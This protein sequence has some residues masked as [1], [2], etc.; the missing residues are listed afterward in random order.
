MRVASRSQDNCSPRRPQQ[1]RGERRVADLLDAAASVFA[2]H[3]YEAATMSQV[4]ERA[5]AC[6]GSLYQFFPNK[7]VLARVLNDRFAKELHSLW[8]P[9][10]AEA[11]T[12]SVAELT[13]R[14]VEISVNLLDRHPALPALLG[15]DVETRSKCAGEILQDCLARIFISRQKL[16]GRTKALHY[17]KVVLQIMKAMAELYTATPANKRAEYVEE[18]KYIL[19]CYLN[20]RIKQVSSTS[21]NSKKV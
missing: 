15:A 3:G 6:I 17:A 2:E 9:L 4:A 8:L 20:S 16:I 7:A 14:I 5:D 1:V 18:F 11:K 12:L 19:S 10:E 13:S 21:P